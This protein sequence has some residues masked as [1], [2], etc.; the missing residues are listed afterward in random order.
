MGRGSFELLSMESV[1]MEERWGM[2]QRLLLYVHY[3]L[4]LQTSDM[5][6][7]F[8]RHNS[9]EET[10]TEKFIGQL[11]TAESTLR[12]DLRRISLGPLLVPTFVRSWESPSSLISSES[13][14]FSS[15]G[16]EVGETSFRRIQ[17]LYLLISR[18]IGLLLLRP[19]NWRM[20][21]YYRP[22]KSACQ[23]SFRYGAENYVFKEEDFDAGSSK[24]L[25]LNL[26][27][28]P[29]DICLRVQQG[30]FRTSVYPL[31]AFNLVSTWIG[32]LENEVSIDNTTI[33]NPT[34]KSVLELIFSVDYGDTVGEVKAWVEVEWLFARKPFCLG[35]LDA[36]SQ[37]EHTETR[38]IDFFTL[39]E[40]LNDTLDGSTSRI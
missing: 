29:H 38:S 9:K 34:L 26:D 37:T 7:R 1:L 10:A 8:I 27:L 4:A 15:L 16:N 5:C 21:G 13:T 31:K 30:L 14:R 20:R 28:L 23:L 24:L 33:Q 39:S 18:Q 35:S 19:R 25:H 12:E 17:L 3:A 2:G 32:I 22:P 6:G 11:K 40:P 36:P